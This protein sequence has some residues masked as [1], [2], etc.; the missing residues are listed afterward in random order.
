MTPPPPLT[1]YQDADQSLLNRGHTCLNITEEKMQ[2]ITDSDDSSSAM[3]ALYVF[4]EILDQI[5]SSNLK[6][7]LQVSPFFAQNL[8]EKISC[9]RQNWEYASFF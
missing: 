1:F 6:F 5:Q 8:L 3:L 4:Q 2:Q 9:Q 7:Q